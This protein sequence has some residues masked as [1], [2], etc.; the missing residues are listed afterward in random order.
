MSRLKRLVSI[1]PLHHLLI[2][3]FFVLE[4]NNE[5]FP[6]VPPADSIRLFF[7]FLLISLVCF[8]ACKAVF[9]EKLRSG[10]ISL[11]LV[12]IILFARTL[13][14]NYSLLWGKDHRVS[15][16]HY[17]LLLCLITG[18]L[19]LL[20]R[21]RSI[22][23]LKKFS[24]YLSFIF[25]A[26]IIYEAGSLLYKSLTA[27]KQ[28]SLQ[29]EGVPEFSSWNGGPKPDIYFLL[30][31]E[32]QGDKGLQDLFGFRD[33]G[34]GTML[35]KKGF[36]VLNDPRSNYNYTFYS[37]PSMLN[38]A[39]LNY[40]D[41]KIDY[42]LRR[43]IKSVDY[44]GE[45]SP[46][47]DQLNRQGYTIVNHSFFRLYNKPSPHPNLVVPKDGYSAIYSRS[48]PGWAQEDLL[49]FIPFNAVQRVF[50]TYF[51]QVFLYNQDVLR[52]METTIDAPPSSPK[53]VYCHLLLPHPPIL[54]D[55]IGNLKNIRAAMYEINRRQSTLPSSYAGYIR[56]SNLVLEQLVTRIQLKDSNAVIIFASDHGFRSYPDRQSDVFNNQCAVYIPGNKYDGFRDD[57]SL[58]NLLR[59]V[60]NN[61]CGL[62]IPLTV[63]TLHLTK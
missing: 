21:R 42:D 9:R 33:Q 38:M 39:Y 2:I 49:H 37:V 43:V 44:L 54:T 59:L 3:V 27:Q 23:G 50:H 53:F 34:P 48:L 55:S 41:Q 26:L 40:S 62:K 4:G 13:Y 8:F 47:L 12:Y 31:D 15:N 56:Y 22:L 20:T 57:L 17:F 19:I 24:Q 11:L 32:Y 45:K 30:F 7:L 10:V 35:R 60:L 63:D 5:F 18:I 61:A 14:N 1:F 28:L 52:G 58:V 25:L 46:F 6:D 51:Y 29:L 36:R 16:T